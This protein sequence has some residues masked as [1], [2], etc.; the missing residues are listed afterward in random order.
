MS[1]EHKGYIE[2]PRHDKPGGFDHA[3]VHGGL[4]R[5]YVAHTANS[6]LDII[7]CRAQQYLHST[8]G[9]PGVAGALV[10]EAENLVFTS[11]RQANAVGILSAVSGDLLGTVPVGLGPNGLAYD[12]TRNLLLA[13]NV[14]DPAIPGSETVS[15]VDTPR[16]GR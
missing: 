15:L 6:A 3:A 14:G 1:L 5:L 16:P 9:L 12:P 4:G 7:D 11:N 2:L 13:A 8:P 10:S